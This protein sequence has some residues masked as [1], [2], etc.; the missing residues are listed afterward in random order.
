MNYLLLYSIS[1]LFD[2]ATSPTH[3]RHIVVPPC[4]VAAMVALRLSV[5]TKS[6]VQEFPFHRTDLPEKARVYR[7]N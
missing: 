7:M 6:Y 4:L 2:G 1:I 3:Q 5:S